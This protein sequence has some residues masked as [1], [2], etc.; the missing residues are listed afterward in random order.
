MIGELG[1]WGTIG[2]GMQADLVLLGGNPLANISNTRDRVGVM[3][4]G[5]WHPQSEL[6]RMLDQVEASYAVEN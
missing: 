1:H 3:L 4:R 5:T 2:S 6:E